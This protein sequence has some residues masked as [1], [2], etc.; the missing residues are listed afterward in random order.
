[1]KCESFL[2]APR[3][4]VPTKLFFTIQLVITW[5]LTA[6]YQLCI[7]TAQRPDEL[8][9][10]RCGSGAQTIPESASVVFIYNVNVGDKVY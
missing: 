3:C 4:A 2:N 6:W 5:D 1:M 8:L 7:G 10:R 9:P